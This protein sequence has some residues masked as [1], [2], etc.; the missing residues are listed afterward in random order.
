MIETTPLSPV[1]RA[2]LSSSAPGDEVAFDRYASPAR[3]SGGGVNVP[4]NALYLAGAAI[5]VVAVL[6]WVGGYFYGMSAKQKELEPAL[7]QA[8][9]PT[10]GDPMA[11][12]TAPAILG[13]V[14]TPLVDISI[15][16]KDSPGGAIPV[17]GSGAILSVR[18]LIASDPR[19]SG[20][21]YLHIERLPAA[22]AERVMGFLYRNGL[23]TIGVPVELS[24]K[25]A[26]NV[27]L[28]SVVALRGITGEQYRQNN[29]VRSGLESEVV[30]LGTI[31]QREF[32]GT[33]NF[34]RSGWM[35]YQP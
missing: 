25:A 34:T 12:S 11:S 18:G 7:R 9:T 6:I 4:I 30:R 8:V 19:Q 26:N 22:D 14:A 21:N 16:V 10:G 27:P 29:K 13:T 5:V 28:Y 31:W 23:E 35:K 1:S 24:K 3:N 2:K 15:S 32:K 17:S 33:T 20:L